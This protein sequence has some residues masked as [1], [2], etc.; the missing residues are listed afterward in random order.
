[1]KKILSLFSFIGFIAVLRYFFV[2]NPADNSSP[3]I[4][5][6]SKRTIHLDCPGCGGQRAFHQLL[7]GHFYEAAKLNILIYIFAPFLT[8]IFLKTALSPFN[9]TLPDVNITGKTILIFG[10]ILVLYTIARNLTF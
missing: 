6:L 1:M 7:H 8:Y 2:N 5:C 10:I 3:F 4:Q 9:I